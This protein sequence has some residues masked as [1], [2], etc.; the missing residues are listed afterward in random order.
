MGGRANER[1]DSEWKMFCNFEKKIFL[2]I[3]Y[4]IETLFVCD[5]VHQNESHCT[6]VVSS[7]YG[8]VSLLASSIL[9]HTFEF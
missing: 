9:L 1:T 6:S 4:G 5:I 8:S 2:P 3:L 7:R